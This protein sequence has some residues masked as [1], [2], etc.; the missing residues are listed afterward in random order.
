P[1]YLIVI[2]LTNGSITYRRIYNR[3]VLNISAYNIRDVDLRT[4]NKSGKQNN[5]SFLLYLEP[6]RPLTSIGQYCY[7]GRIEEQSVNI[8]VGENPHSCLNHAYSIDSLHGVTVQKHRCIHFDAKIVD[9]VPGEYPKLFRF[10]EVRVYK[11]SSVDSTVGSKI[12]YHYHRQS[13]ADYLNTNKQLTGKNQPNKTDFDIYPKTSTELVIMVKNTSRVGYHPCSG[14]ITERFNTSEQTK[15]EIVKTQA[16]VIYVKGLHA[17]TAY[18][19]CLTCLI[20]LNVYEDEQCKFTETIRMSTSS[21][22]V[23]LNQPARPLGSRSLDPSSGHSVQLNSTPS[24]RSLQFGTECDD[25]GIP[26]S[27]V[28]VYITWPSIISLTTNSGEDESNVL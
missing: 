5:P 25:D 7:T 26:F 28:G 10:E 2:R 9:A 3:Q 15:Q 12:V 21:K 14:Y 19:I 16:L 24:Y 17:A 20:S 6:Y 8:I 11:E 27:G 13:V 4:G 23:L 22:V 18:K 1:S